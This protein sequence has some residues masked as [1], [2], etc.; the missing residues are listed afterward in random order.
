MARVWAG[1]SDVDQA[2]EAI[3]KC[4]EETGIVPEALVRAYWTSIERS[5]HGLVQRFYEKLAA[6]CPKALGYFAQKPVEMDKD[7]PS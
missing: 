4:I 1:K 6:K 7:S 5:T 3:A 2:V